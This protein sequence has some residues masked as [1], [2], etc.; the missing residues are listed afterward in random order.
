MNKTAMEPEAERT[1]YGK[2]HA[3]ADECTIRQFSKCRI[4]EITSYQLKKSREGS[5]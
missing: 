4:K 1:Y 3:W 5:Y 2:L